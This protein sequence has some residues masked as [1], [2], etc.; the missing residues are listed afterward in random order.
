L[1][2]VSYMRTYRIVAA[3]SSKRRSCLAS[4]ALGDPRAISYVRKYRHVSP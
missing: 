2:K 3:I 1:R 4:S